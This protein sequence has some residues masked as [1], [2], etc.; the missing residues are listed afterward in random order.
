MVLRAIEPRPGRLGPAQPRATP[1][2]VAQ[3]GATESS[4]L[5]NEASVP[6]ERH[7]R[8]LPKTSDR[9]ASSQLGSAVET[10]RREM[11]R[12][13]AVGGILQNKPNGGLGGLEMDIAVREIDNDQPLMPVIFTRRW[14]WR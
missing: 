9:G 5:Q 4:I 1:R 7:F 11:S 10:E 6:G 12:F 13:V 14:R 3:P 8:K 2:N